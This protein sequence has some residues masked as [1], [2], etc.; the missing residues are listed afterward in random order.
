[1]GVVGNNVKG[2]QFLTD[3][4]TIESQ[5]HRAWASYISR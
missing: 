4:V 2:Q 3:I 5:Y 1:M